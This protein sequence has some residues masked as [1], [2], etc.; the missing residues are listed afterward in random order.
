MDVREIRRD[1]FD[2]RSDFYFYIVYPHKRE[3]LFHWFRT[4]NGEIN[5][6]QIAEKPNYRERNNASVTFR[7]VI[8]IYYAMSDRS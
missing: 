4:K 3:V 2:K 6:E 5:Y 8:S 1:Y 7:I